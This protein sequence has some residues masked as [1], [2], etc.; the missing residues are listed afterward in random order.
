MYRSRF[1]VPFPVLADRNRQIS[2]RF[3]DVV[4]PLLIALKKENGKW[5]E[6][7]RENRIQG[8]AAKIYQHIQP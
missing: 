5:Q 6:F 7:Y 3:R 2:S 1:H 8:E 4:P